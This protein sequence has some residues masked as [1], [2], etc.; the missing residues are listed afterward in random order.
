MQ[1]YIIIESLSSDS[2]LQIAMVEVKVAKKQYAMFKII[3]KLKHLPEKTIH[4]FA[5]WNE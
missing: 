5:D 4:K 2:N 1:A 3:L